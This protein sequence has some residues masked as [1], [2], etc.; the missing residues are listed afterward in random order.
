MDQYTLSIFSMTFLNHQD[1]LYW[2]ISTEENN[3]HNIIKT[4][5]YLFNIKV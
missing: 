1:M 3:L 4:Q 5:M 2:A